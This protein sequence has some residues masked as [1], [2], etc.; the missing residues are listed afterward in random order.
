MLLIK[1]YILS[2]IK[3]YMLSRMN[4]TKL[5]QIEESCFSITMEYLNCG[6]VIERIT[7]QD[8]RLL[9]KDVQAI[10]DCAIAHIGQ[11]PINFFTKSRDTSIATFSYYVDITENI[12]DRKSASRKSLIELLERV[13]V[14]YQNNQQVRQALRILIEMRSVAEIRRG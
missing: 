8:N 2:N 14:K 5:K 11:P 9:S 1:Y 12:R 6:L 10:L 13:P 4:G 7:N 3:N